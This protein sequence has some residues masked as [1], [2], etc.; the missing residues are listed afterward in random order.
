V[1]R[2]RL[3]GVGLHGGTR[4]AVVFVAAPGPTTLGRGDD[5][6][7]LGALEVRG[8]DHASIAR[9][10]SGTTIR[11]V[12]HL[13][14][15]IAGLR[16]FEGLR[17]DLEGEE[18]PLFD[19]GASE[20]CR[21]IE[22]IAPGTRSSPPRAH[23]KI[24]RAASYALDDASMSLAPGD[25]TEIEVEIAFEASR[26]GRALAG[27]ARW[28]GDASSFVS[29]IA[30]SRTFGAAAELESLRARGLASHVP[31]GAVIAIDVDDPDWAPR[32]PEE[33]IRHKLLDLIGDLAPLGAPL[34]GTLVARRPSHRTT[35]TMLGR[36]V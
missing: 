13:L 14:A 25:G 30:P 36:A 32:D 6:A 29:E 27:T 3:E 28:L 10:P 24:T 12:E 31:K 16:A 19:G 26:F 2:V 18:I 17:V 11:T 21:A 4:G 35:R 1:E 15:A 7:A 23:A 33:P 22:A 9:L 5:R 20:L 8:A 34:L